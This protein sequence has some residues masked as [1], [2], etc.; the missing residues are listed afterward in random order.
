MLIAAAAVGNVKAV[1]MLLDRG[2]DTEAKNDARGLVGL[3]TVESEPASMHSQ[4]RREVPGLFGYHV[5]GTAISDAEAL[6]Q[7]TQRDG[8]VQ[9]LPSQPQV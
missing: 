4:C 9:W 8:I 6:Q 5:G 1:Q 7:G 3:G 2:A